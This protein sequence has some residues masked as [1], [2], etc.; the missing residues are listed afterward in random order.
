[1]SNV[2]ISYEISVNFRKFP[3]FP[4]TYTLNLYFLV[5][6]LLNTDNY[7]M[8]SDLLADTNQ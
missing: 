4:V 5:V 3:K 6:S 8:L 7:Q 2:V 1:M